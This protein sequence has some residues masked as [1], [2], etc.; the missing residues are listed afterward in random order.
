MTNQQVNFCRKF[1]PTTP[2]SGAFLRLPSSGA[3][4]PLSDVRQ[5]ATWVTWCGMTYLRPSFRCSQNVMSGLSAPVW[6]AAKAAPKAVVS[7]DCKARAWPKRWRALSWKQQTNKHTS[8]DKQYC[9]TS[10]PLSGI[11]QES[12]SGC[13]ARCL[14]TSTLFGKAPNSSH[15]WLRS[16]HS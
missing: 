12:P 6:Q 4:L 8:N 2:R 11:C 16:W 5:R 9:N 13:L 14:T 3:K 10:A 1:H 7:S 15:D